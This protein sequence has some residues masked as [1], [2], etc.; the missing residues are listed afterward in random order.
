MLTDVDIEK[1]DATQLVPFYWMAGWLYQ[2]DHDL[3][4]TD[5]AWDLLCKRLDAEWDEIEHR[6][7]K[8]IKREDLETATAMRHTDKRTPLIAQIAAWRMAQKM[9]GGLDDNDRD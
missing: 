9:K 2:N 8:K 5:P 3:I 7:K 6:H 1:L 4:M